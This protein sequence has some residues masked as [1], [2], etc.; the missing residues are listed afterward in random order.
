MGDARVPSEDMGFNV[1]GFVSGNF[2][3]A[4][5]A[6]NTIKML[7]ERGFAVRIVDLDA[8]GGRSGHDSTYSHLDS[9]G[10]VEAP[11]SVN[12]FHMNPPDVVLLLRD[13]PRWLDLANRMNVCVPFWELP[14]LPRQDFVPVLEAMDMVLCPTRFVMDTVQSSAP[15]ARCVYYPQTAFIPDGVQPNRSSFGLDEGKTLFMVALDL[16]SDIDRKNPWAAIEA[17]RLAFGDRD[18]VGLVV[19]VNNPKLNQ[20]LAKGAA[21]LRELVAEMPGVLIVDRALSYP[22]VLSLYASCD[23]LLSLH[24]SEGLG[25]HLIE[26]MQLGKPVI[27]TNWSGNL[28]FTTPENSRLIDYKLVPVVSTHPSYAPKIIGDGQVWAE[29]D[30]EQAA[31]AMRELADDPA[32]RH[33]LGDRARADTLA[34]QRGFLEGRE[35]RNGICRDCRTRHRRC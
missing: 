26:A 30:V 17:Y 16:G 28:D 23:V 29:P 12:L 14:K 35:R 27:A 22:E 11:Y 3:L 31:R 6:R 18:D 25:L 32:L 10:Q 9:S 8:G 2:G 15:L 19:K 7:T 21:R 34:Q 33:H 1:I 24:R 4:V 5:A 20:H 13:R